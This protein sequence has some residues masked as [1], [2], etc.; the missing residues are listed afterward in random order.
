MCQD[1]IDLTVA[2]ADK[3][4]AAPPLGLLIGVTTLVATGAY[5][6]GE[7]QSVGYGAE[8]STIAGASACIISA[9]ALHLWVDHKWRVRAR[10]F[11]TRLGAAGPLPL[12][13]LLA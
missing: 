7:S 10:N 6:V 12:H 5:F 4:A 3:F 11:R 9:L 1:V 8:W 13:K 2:P